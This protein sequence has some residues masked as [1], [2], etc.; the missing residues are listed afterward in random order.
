MRTTWSVG[1]GAAFVGLAAMT[2]SA[3]SVVYTIESTH[4]HDEFATVVDTAG[5]QDGDGVADLLIGAPSDS[6][7]ATHAGTAAV[8]SGRS[9]LRIWRIY[10]SNEDDQLGA[11]VAGVNDIDHDGVRDLL[12][13]IPGISVLASES[14]QAII[15]SSVTSQPV[16]LINWPFHDEGYGRYAWNI[17]DANNDGVTDYGVA[18][19]ICLDIF[20]S[21]LPELNC[22]SGLSGAELSPLHTFDPQNMAAA[23]DTNGDGKNEILLAHYGEAHLISGTSGGVYDFGPPTSID[24]EPGIGPGGDFDGDGLNDYILASGPVAGIQ[25]IQITSLPHGVL[26]DLQI[27]LVTSPLGLA[28]AFDGTVDVDQDGI[29]DLIVGFPSASTSGSP[30]FAGLVRIYSGTSGTVVAE[31][32]GQVA[33]EAFGKSVRVLGDINGDGFPELAVSAPATSAQL[34]VPGRVRVCTLGPVPWS[35]DGSSLAGGAGEP[36]LTGTGP[37]VSATKLKVSLTDA[38]A[39]A[40]AMLVVGLSTLSVPF[41]GGV[42]GPFPFLLLGPV[43]VAGNPMPLIDATWPSGIAPGLHLYMQAWIQDA[44]GPAG[45]SAT[46]TLVATTPP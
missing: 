30:P 4:L 31:I 8:Y 28:T 27:P 37:L 11:A 20:V 40:P 18:S 24:S 17:G 42:L 34:N 32:H 9:G 33:D 3:Q 7:M 13:G 25:Y 29:L 46:D 39:G 6:T 41:K 12:I 23:G 22:Y 15:Y 10:G 38:L 36:K 26:L 5:D 35:H 19:T 1:V 16:R 45:F 43:T 14:G 2:A 44:A 21:P